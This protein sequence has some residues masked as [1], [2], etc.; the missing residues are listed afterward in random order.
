LPVVDEVSQMKEKKKKLEDKQ[1]QAENRISESTE[2]LG[3]ALKNIKIEDALHA[4]ALLE[5]RTWQQ[6]V[7]RLKI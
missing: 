2:R 3:T 1:Q 6:Q 5:S 4:Q 7:E